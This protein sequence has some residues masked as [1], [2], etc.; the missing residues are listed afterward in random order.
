[1][2]ARARAFLFDFDG[3]L[4]QQRIDFGLMRRAVMEVLGQHGAD[5]APLAGMHI[6]EA[7][8]RATAQIAPADPARARAAA[9]ASHRAI[10]AIELEAAETA[11]AF[12]GVPELL[13]HLRASGWGVAIVTRNCRVAVER[14]LARTPLPH[15][16][17]LTRDDVLHVKPDPRHLLA[18]LE[19]LGVAPE[20]AVMCGDHPMDV[21]AGKR[22]GART[23]GV[24][25][26]G[27]GADYFAQARPDLVIARVTDL[28]AYLDKDGA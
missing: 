5:T 18:A 1:M 21:L 25:P 27:A 12:P 15:D 2:F 23:V 16:V 7:V 20:E 4:I 24:L 14:V 13:Q 10:T 6:L 11:T 26:D 22:I 28:R 3:T 17:L 19:R 9:E 8:E